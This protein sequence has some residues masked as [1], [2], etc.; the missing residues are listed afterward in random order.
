M[1][2][3]NYTFVPAEDYCERYRQ[4]QHLVAVGGGHCGSTETTTGEHQTTGTVLVPDQAQSAALGWGHEN[5][6]ELD[7]ILLLLS[8]F[9]GHKVFVLDPDEE[10]GPIIADPREFQYGGSVGLSLGKATRKDEWGYDDYSLNLSAGTT[11]VILHIRSSTWQ[12]IY[13][14]GRF[15]FLF[16]S[17]CHRQILETSFLLCWTAWEHLFALHNSSTMSKKKLQ[18]VPA[19]DKIGDMIQKYRIKQT[20]PTAHQ[21]KLE[22]LAEI[23]NKLVHEG[24]FATV[25]AQEVAI[26]FIR[27]TEVVIAKI[28]G[29]T[30]SN[31]F[32][33]EE[34]FD[35]FLNNQQLI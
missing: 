13:G 15:L 8:I 4:L 34:R 24:A 10:D 3:G 21:K 6:T 2:I 7:D 16:G 5:A 31:V 28:L 33:P 27:L 32:S 12:S 19:K 17:A 30:P 29:L 23:R 9:T 26:V 22:E 11:A 18:K 1:K 20:V 25:Y 35:R 14:D